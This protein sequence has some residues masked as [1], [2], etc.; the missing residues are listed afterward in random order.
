MID[1]MVKGV[2]GAVCSVDGNIKIVGVYI[3]IPNVPYIYA[4]SG[5]YQL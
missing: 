2:N 4:P 5:S 3:S 1:Y